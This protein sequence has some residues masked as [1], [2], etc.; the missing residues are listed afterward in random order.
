LWNSVLDVLNESGKKNQEMESTKEKW[1]QLDELFIE[2][3]HW[4]ESA[5]RKCPDLTTV[6]S[7][8]TMDH[9]R[10]YEVR[11]IMEST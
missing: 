5:S 8:L 2:E 10:V 6:S 11:L 1:R 7:S 3:S 9:K 4:L